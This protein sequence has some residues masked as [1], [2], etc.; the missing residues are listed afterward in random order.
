M[1]H[2][3]PSFLLFLPQ[4]QATTVSTVTI[5]YTFDK[6]FAFLECHVV[7]IVHLKQTASYFSGKNWLGN[8]KEL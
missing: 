4:P 7:G 3:Y 5:V 1:F 8:N 2:L 6:V